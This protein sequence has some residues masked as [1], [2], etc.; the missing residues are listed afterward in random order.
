[1]KRILSCDYS[2]NAFRANA[3]FFLFILL[4]CAGKVETLDL[5]VQTNSFNQKIYSSE[6]FKHLVISNNKK[7]TLLHIYIEGDGMPW[8]SRFLLSQDPTPRNPLTLKLMSLD[9]NRSIYVGRPCYFGLSHSKNC[10]S[11]RWTSGRYS[12]EVISSMVTVIK[13]YLKEKKIKQFLLIG[14]S[15]GGVIAA[16]LADRFDKKVQYLT[17]ASNLDIDKWADYH[18][19]SRLIHSLNPARKFT[20]K[21]NGIHLVGSED[22]NVP[23]HLIDDFVN[24]TNN[25]LVVF[26]N[27]DHVCCWVDNWYSILNKYLGN[28]K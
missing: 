10:S 3:V 19:Y 8:A 5:I 11:K 16:L 18:G 17:I 21:Q 15:G 24:Q 23:R 4:G 14:Y 26:E 6:F 25:K 27:Y 9:S 7:E 28:I 1:M 20:T 22:V 12:E 13:T 2:M